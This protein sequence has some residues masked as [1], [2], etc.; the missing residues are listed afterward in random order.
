MIYVSSPLQ[1]ELLNDRG[2]RENDS[3]LCCTRGHSLNVCW[4]DLAETM[5]VNTTG[6]NAI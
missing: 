5:F 4:I 1:Y 2:G 3:L 6:Y